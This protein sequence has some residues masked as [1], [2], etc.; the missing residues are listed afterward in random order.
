MILKY[1]AGTVAVF[2]AVLG[3]LARPAAYS[4]RESIEV[5]GM[6]FVTYEY[7][8][9]EFDNVYLEDAPRAVRVQYAIFEELE[10]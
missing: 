3:L 7:A 6:P 5:D 4:L 1:I 10:K 8:E 2:V 9:D